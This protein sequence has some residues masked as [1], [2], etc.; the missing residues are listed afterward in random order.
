MHKRFHLR[1][2]DALRA[3]LAAAGLSLPIAEDLAILG[4]AVAVGGRSAPNRLLVQPMEGFDSTPDGSPG[5][6]SF[7][8]YLRYAEGG[9]GL[10]WFEATAVLHEARS[11]PRQLVLHAGSVASFARLVAATRQAARDAFGHEIIAILQLTHSGRY[12]KPGGLP[13]P[14][15]AHHSA[16]LDP[17]HRLSP[18][19]PLVSD[20][21]LDRLQDIYVE[22]ARLARDAGFDGVDLKACHRYLVSELLASHTR[23]GKYGTTLEN[24]S[25]FL[26]ETV[27]K[28]RDSVPGTFVT[29]RIN[30]YDAI[31]YPYGFGVSRDEP[32]RPD[33]SEPIEVIR[34]LRSLGIALVNVTVGNPYYNPHF[35]R[36]YD[37]PIAGVDVP[38]HPLEGVTRLVDVTRQVQQAVPD[39]PVVAT[40]YSWLRHLMPHVAAGVVQS[41]W[42][43]LVGQGRSAFAYPDAARDILRHGRMDP[44]KTCIACS[45]CSQIMRDGTM[46][47]CVVR[48][49]KIYGEQYKLGRRYAVDRLQEAARRCRDCEFPTCTANC[50]ARVD[51]PT[52]VRAFA[53]GRI[54]EAYDVLRRSNVLPELCAR[55][56][57]SEVQCE[58]GCLERIFAD[59]ALPVRDIQL[60][61]CRLAR[62]AGMIGV[63][64]PAQA[65]GFRVA[66]VGGGPAGL[67]CAFRLLEHGHQVT[68]FERG[69]RVGGTPDSLIPCDRY[70]SSAEEIDAI[71]RAAQATDRVEIRLGCALGRDFSLAHVQSHYDAVLL[72]LGLDKSQSLATAEGVVDALGFLRDVKRGKIASL[73]GRVAVLGG[74]NTAVD[75]AVTARRLGAADVFVVYRRSS[76]EMPAWPDEQERLRRA[77]CHLL[78]LTQPLCY[79]TDGKGQL[80]G[81]RVARTELGEPDASG[82]RAP[83]LIPGSE[84]VLPV[85]IVIEAIG[86][87]VPDQLRSVLEGIEFTRHGLVATRPESQATSLEGV[88][89]AGD[90]VNGGTTAVQGVAEGMKA[91]EEIHAWLHRLRAT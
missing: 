31:P 16:V 40:G 89:A 28:I 74:G 91:A 7:R 88:F 29:T 73:A 78:I 11:N 85:D 56:C 33:L 90:L 44:A 82:R 27:E 46:T 52:F 1:D 47:G 51:V 50:P 68:I 55:V 60:V 71:L 23:E 86:Q 10:I 22:A 65:S 36:P 35:G 81:L 48:D 69:E 75:A 42:A 19:Y 83:R 84:H 4:E 17:K 34:A 12:S 70:E 24:R 41:G 3:E 21:Y 49:S 13:R 61:V 15:I 2:L 45:G 72:A 77:N 76:A 9:S 64:L 57:P 25:R 30:V 20:D 80:V 62:Q 59:H 58:G 26:R 14:M 63:R 39:L 66:V 5:S 6:L 8:R 32:M 54:P 18:D 53:D 79:E 37:R 43:A 87:G 67:A 38:E